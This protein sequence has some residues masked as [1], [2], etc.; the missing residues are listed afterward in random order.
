MI[1][2]SAAVEKTCATIER[3]YEAVIKMIDIHIKAAIEKGQFTTQIRQE[4][5]EEEV[6]LY[7]NPLEINSILRVFNESGYE[8]CYNVSGNIQ[9]SW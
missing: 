1:E 5:F 6:G 9:I 8:V 7:L 2:A 4:M 3:N